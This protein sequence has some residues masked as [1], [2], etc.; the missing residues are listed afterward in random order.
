MSRHHPTPADDAFVRLSGAL[1]ALREAG[2]LIEREPELSAEML[3]SLT[4]LMAL[5]GQQMRD[6]TD[7]IGRKVRKISPGKH[8]TALPDTVTG[9]LYQ[10]NRDVES[11]RRAFQQVHEDFVNASNHI[12]HLQRAGATTT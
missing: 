9:L 11:A 10:A 2:A 6:F 8:T 12:G 4:G 7:E 1:A 3:A 5:Y